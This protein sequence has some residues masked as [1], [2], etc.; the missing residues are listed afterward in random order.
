MVRIRALVVAA[1]ALLGLAA[2]AAPAA[3]PSAASS[4]GGAASWQET[5][6]QA[7]GQT[8]SLWMWGGDPKGNAYVD[9]VLA[10]AAQDLGVRL[11]RV[12]IA[13]TKDAMN[14]ILAE[15]RAGITDGEV[16]L[17][18][19]NGDNF[20]TGRQADAWRCDWASTLPHARYLAPADPLLTNDFGTAVQGCE[21]PWHKAQFT[22]V[23]DAARVPDPPTTM[24]GCRPSS[25][26]RRT[27]G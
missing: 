26:R 2:C 23:Y 17:V 14:R 12:P 7:S 24:A 11:R 1:V 19:V 9:G 4:P 16:D 13:D 18:W 6:S 3:T 25:T 20:A 8:V 22:L 15:R 21:S 27:T 10:P 5:L